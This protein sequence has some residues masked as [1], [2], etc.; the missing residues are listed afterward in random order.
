LVEHG[1]DW[2]APLHPPE[3]EADADDTVA[4]RGELSF[5]L[6]ADGAN[7]GTWPTGLNTGPEPHEVAN[8]PGCWR[9][10]GG[11]GNLNRLPAAPGGPMFDPGVR[12]KAR[13]GAG[14][15]RAPPRR[16]SS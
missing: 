13:Y 14:D 7:L 5:D 15:R 1:R 12:Q 6:A 2:R 11:A 4:R 9:G 10:E 16:I 8:Q 3:A